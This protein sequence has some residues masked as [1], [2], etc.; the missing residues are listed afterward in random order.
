MESSPTGRPL[1]TNKRIAFANPPPTEKPRQESNIS[2]EEHPNIT[3]DL[4]GTL[5]LSPDSGAS[6]VQYGKKHIEEKRQL[7]EKLTKNLQGQQQVLTRSSEGD[8][9]NTR[10]TFEIANILYKHQKPF[11]DRQI[12]QECLK[13]FAEVTYGLRHSISIKGEAECCSLVLNKS[14]DIRDTAE[15]AIFIPAVDKDFNVAEEL[16]DMNPLKNTARDIAP[17]MIGC[18]NGLIIKVPEFKPNVIVVHCIIYQ[19]NLSA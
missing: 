15:L 5:S 4:Q 12:V 17:S 10:L 18:H 13:K 1:I 16:L 11:S 2:E 19:E 6:G 3:N 9:A 14:T 8:I 7:P